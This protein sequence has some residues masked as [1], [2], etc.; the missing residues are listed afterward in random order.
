MA[1]PWAGELPEP[2]TA[3]QPEKALRRSPPAAQPD[4]LENGAEPGG[5]AVPGPATPCPDRCA[6]YRPAAATGFACAKQMTKKN[7]LGI[8][9]GL[10]SRACR[11][12]RPACLIPLSRNCRC[13]MLIR[14]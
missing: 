14:S 7:R 9:A 5:F 3:H 10:F 12:W 6:Q 13:S 1:R 11:Y 8:L 4:W 2:D